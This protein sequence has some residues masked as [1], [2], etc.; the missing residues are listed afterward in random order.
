MGT[1][2]NEE[3]PED[4]VLDD[5]RYRHWCMV[6]EDKNGGVDGTKDILH[7]KKWDLY[8]SDNEALVKGGYSVEVTNKDSN[9]AIW[10][11]VDDHVDEE[12]VDHE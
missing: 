7:A 6:F 2:P 5:E 8:Y 4:V 9:K 3:D 12:G 11:V 1:D 10:E